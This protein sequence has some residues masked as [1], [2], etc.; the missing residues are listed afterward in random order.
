MIQMTIT[1]VALP[2]K[3]QELLQT[4]Q[5]LTAG[6]RQEKGFLRGS[7][8]MNGKNV[9]KFI[10]AWE[11]P[12]DLNAYLQS[13]YFSVLRGAMKV[14]TSSAEIEFSTNGGQAHVRNHDQS[15]VG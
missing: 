11:T 14:L 15:P 6:M 4:L 1:M 12:E 9:M 8:G 3:E 5:E 10:E 13:Y 7:V 2:T